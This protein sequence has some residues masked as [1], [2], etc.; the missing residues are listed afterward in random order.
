[1]AEKDFAKAYFY[2]SQT[3]TVW[4]KPVAVSEVRASKGMPGGH[5]SLSANGETG[6]ILWTSYAQDDGQWAQVHGNFCAFDALT[7]QEI[8]HDPEDVSN[9][10]WFAKFNPP[11]VTHGRVFRPCFAQYHAPPAPPPAGEAPTVVSGGKV[12]V[13][14]ISIHLNL[15][16]HKRS[17]PP[18][19]ES[20]SI[21]AKWR[22][23]RG[24]AIMRQPDGPEYPLADGRGRRRDFVGVVVSPMQGI[25]LRNLP[26][27]G[28]CDN[29]PTEW[30]EIATS[31][32]WSP[33]TGAHL[34]TAEIRDEYLRRG[35]ADGE[36]GYPISDETD[37]KH[38][39]GRVS[40]FERGY[41][42]WSSET[43]PIAHLFPSPDHDNPN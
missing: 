15:P 25:S 14:G 43:G 22:S 1:M 37:L 35:H 34:V 13:Y 41:I 6:G 17:R 33:E 31:V 20:A 18:P 5:S 40:Y 4:T 39:R 24:S 27:G 16:H 30:V 36:L 9:P 3:G 23:H 32:F 11:T 8:W 2:D 21:E 26:L 42:I 12:I 7:L 38:D 28:S 10:S 19:D 29:P